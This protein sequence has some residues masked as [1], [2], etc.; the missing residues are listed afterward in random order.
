MRRAA[1]WR[2]PLAA[3]YALIQLPELALVAIPLY[4]MVAVGW[5]PAR[6]AWIAAAAWVVKDVL[7]YPLYRHALRDAP[8]HGVAALVGREAEVV[9]ALAPLG[10]VRLQGERWRAR[11]SDGTPLRPGQRVVVTGYRGLTLE[12]RAAD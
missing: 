9:E 2:L 10:Q 1:A 5:L 6:W 4:L 7:L 8:P 12:V 3:R 11:S